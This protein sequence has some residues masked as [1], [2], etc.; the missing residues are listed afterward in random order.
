MSHPE[1][2]SSTGHKSEKCWHLWCRRGLLDSE[3]NF[4]NSLF[5]C[6]SPV[7][8]I[9]DPM[10]FDVDDEDC[11]L[12]RRGCFCFPSFRIFGS[13]FFIEDVSYPQVFGSPRMALTR[14]LPGLQEIGGTFLGIFH[15]EIPLF[16]SVSFFF[17]SVFFFF[18][19]LPTL[20]VSLSF[21][22]FLLILNESQR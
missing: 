9:A 8:R 18:F 15:S 13:L 5:A 14:F 1:W 10:L 4:A 2:F 20:T 6:L 12:D 7:D 17:L 19:S 11:K 21:L 3:V 16:P 22:R